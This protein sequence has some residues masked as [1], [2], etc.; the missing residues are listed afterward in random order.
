VDS[1]IAG[2]Q[3]LPARA[4]TWRWLFSAPADAFLTWS[5][6]PAFAL[7]HALTSQPGAGASRAV[8]QLL[9]I[10]ML[11]S[12]AHQPLTLLL[13]YADRGQFGQRPRLF[14]WAPVLA[15]AAVTI[16]VVL[17]L[18]LI[19]P[20]AA[21][22][23]VI[24][25]LQQRY[26]LLRIYARKARYGN[27]RLDRALVYVPFAAALAV[28]AASPAAM[29]QFE[30]F[31]VA[32][33][34]QA[35]E[36]RLMF[37]YR[38]LFLALAIPLGLAALAVLALYGS[39]EHAAVQEGS[40]NPGKWQ[41]AGSMLL[42]TCGL[43]YDPLAGLIA[44]VAGH[45]IEY[46]VVVMNTLRSRY[47]RSASTR[48]LLA[49][50]AG[51]TS[52]RWALLITFLGVFL[53]LDVQAR[54]TL[55]AGSY[56]I[57]IYTVGLLHFVYDAVIW[58]LRKPAVATDLG[59][60]VSGAPAAITESCRR[61]DRVTWGIWLMLGGRGS[62]GEAL[63]NG[64]T[65]RGGNG[66]AYL[67]GGGIASWR[68]Q[69]SWYAMP[70][71]TVRGSGSWK[72]VRS[73][74]ARWTG[75]VIRNGLRHPWRPHAG[76]RGLRLPVEPAGHHPVAGGSGEDGQAGDLGLQPGVA[77]ALRRAPDRPHPQDPRRGRPRLQRPGPAPSSSP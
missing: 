34:G 71:P 49:A 26:G 8:A 28:V 54:D 30:R 63:S 52:R 39:Q 25:T 61:L 32:L 3:T 76:G 24:H 70:G 67:I 15:L 55:P 73:P 48:S 44:M 2:A 27:A 33:G 12:L 23:Q 4:W 75:P 41:Y 1:G 65:A 5:W 18:W 53:L 6:V 51:S 37:S 64:A 10:V 11:A 77:H 35:Q 58:K 9:T 19:V 50:W 42:L 74:A 45:A 31:G 20:I 7:A 40:A 46:C 38:A 14:T 43:V 57:A 29:S 22:W 13:V 17:N 66:S 59:I 68:R 16:A 21:A 69:C 47:G 56:L 72:S 36:I 62:P 60:T